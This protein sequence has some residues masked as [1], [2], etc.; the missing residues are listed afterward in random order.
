M[1]RGKRPKAAGAGA[2]AMK[3]STTK[4]VGESSEKIVAVEKAAEV[5]FPL[6][7]E[8]REQFLRSRL[9]AIDDLL[10]RFEETLLALDAEIL[11]TRFEACGRD[12]EHAPRKLEHAGV[13]ERRLER[14]LGNGCAH[15]FA[16]F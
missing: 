9:A 2:A 13:A 8:R 10:Q 11:C 1:W 7:A 4:L 16:L 3:I 5:A 15:R 14:E 6:A 12:R